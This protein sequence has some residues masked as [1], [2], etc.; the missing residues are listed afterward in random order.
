M[1]ETDLKVCKK[2][3][4][5]KPRTL[6]YF[7]ADKT[8]DDGFRASCKLCRT[9]SRSKSDPIA[10]AES[11]LKAHEK[12]FRKMTAFLADPK[13]SDN[14]LI[15]AERWVRNEEKKRKKLMEPLLELRRQAAK[16]AEEQSNATT[17]EK[18]VA[19]YP[20][21][22]TAPADRDAKLAVLRA[23][24]ASLTAQTQ[25][26]AK[27]YVHNRILDVVEEQTAAARVAA[28]QKSLAD[29]AQ[30]KRDQIACKKAAADIVA[31]ITPFL[32][33]QKLN[34]T[35]RAR[36][37]DHCLAQAKACREVAKSETGFDQSGASH[38]VVADAMR[39][40]Y[41]RFAKELEIVDE[42][43]VYKREPSYFLDYA[44]CSI[45]WN[46]RQPE[47]RAWLRARAKVVWSD[48]NKNTDG[49]PHAP[50]PIS[51]PGR[52]EY[53]LKELRFRETLAI[54]SHWFRE[55]E[56]TKRQQR[57]AKLKADNPEEFARVMVDALRGLHV[58]Y[59]APAGS[60]WLQSDRD[61]WERMKKEDPEK[62]RRE[63]MQL[64]KP[65][66][67]DLPT[68]VY[69][70]PRWDAEHPNKLPD[71]YWPHGGEVVRGKDIVHVHA[72]FNVARGTFA[73][74]CKD[75]FCG[76]WYRAPEP[77][78]VD[79]SF[80][81]SNSRIPSEEKLAAMSP[82]SQEFWRD[83]AAREA[84]VTWTQAA[85]GSWQPKTLAANLFARPNGITFR[86]ADRHI[87]DGGGRDFFRYGF[88]WTA[89]EIDAVENTPSKE[90]PQILPPLSKFTLAD[91]VAVKP[92]TDE[93]RRI[94]SLST[95][96]PW[97]RHERGQRE[98]KVR[99][100]ELL[101]Q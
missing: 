39:K 80:T 48:F 47:E 96:T 23:L 32:L 40:T 45:N 66:Q 1:P 10:V 36:L 61:H 60:S 97:Q 64:L 73:P 28:A 16:A 92:E 24:H 7:N 77:V 54:T 87:T 26:L 56:E 43:T 55:E 5:A 51:L 52:P 82:E 98:A 94:E 29:E 12:M 44:V 65:R 84:G 6:E 33:T 78:D 50:E 58:Q 34:L 27:D 100:Q 70:V 63:S 49:I 72:Q 59:G 18:I 25:Q 38:A 2:C 11:R 79:S 101:A 46:F 74:R 67:T 69:V 9:A 95:E 41:S 30:T 91:S 13:T 35:K 86:K 20:E 17:L 83:E 88:W 3:G 62:Y 37:R 71:L 57:L 31:W 93:T 75:I 21:G 8:R 4:E 15:E 14:R 76:H 90:P 53:S 89:Q 68:I 42:V 99:T 85:D 81:K 19:E 22:S